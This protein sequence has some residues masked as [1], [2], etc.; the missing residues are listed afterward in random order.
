MKPRSIASRLAWMF[1]LAVTA[2]LSIAAL[3]LFLFMYHELQRHKR[4]ELHARHVIVERL[5]R[6]VD[7]LERWRHFAAKLADFSPD[8]GSLYFLAAS[9]DPR[10]RIGEDVLQRLQ[11]RPQAFAEGGNGERYARAKLDGRRFVTLVHDLPA[12]G[13]RPPVRLVIAAA[14]SDVEATV[15]AV[16]AAIAMVLLLSMLAVFALGWRIARHGLAP[17]DRLSEHARRLDARD[18]ARRLPDD[19]LPAELEGLVLALNQALARLEHAYLKL[20]AFNADVAHE[21]RTPLGNLI[22]ETQVALSRPRDSAALETVLQSN[23]EELE[24]LRGIV[25]AM[26]FLARADRGESA[27]DPIEVSLRED[28]RKAAEF[29]EILLD[30]AGTRLE[31]VGDARV[32][33]ED[34]LYARAMTNLIDNALRHGEPGGTVLV[35]IADSDDE[36]VV[37]VSNP[38]GP[39]PQE[40]LSHLF[41]RF[42]RADPSRTSSDQHQGLGLAIVKAIVQLHGGSVF[43]RCGEGRVQ[44]GFRLPRRPPG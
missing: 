25:N 30:D 39:I 28:T 1:G 34:S 22:G 42:Y 11:I 4:E 21:L 12:D 3:A 2:V 38:G 41:D 20:S 14:M 15:V 7:D 16:T 29:L 10:W 31:I 9:D 8:D 18:L 27:R 6:H 24:R 5:V 43:A 36:A 19:A 13:Q 44:V 35:T 17:V 26:L 23:L 37:T 32:R 33:V 40:Q